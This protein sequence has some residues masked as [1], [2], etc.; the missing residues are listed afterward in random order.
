MKSKKLDSILLDVKREFIY[1][2]ISWKEIRELGDATSATILKPESD[3]F[4]VIG[5]IGEEGFAVLNFEDMESEPKTTQ[6]FWENYKT[7]KELL[8][9]LSKCF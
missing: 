5:K 2:L 9:E 8:P 1:N 7:N 6:F 3:G 4:Y